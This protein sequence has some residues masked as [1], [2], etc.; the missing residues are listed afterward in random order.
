MRGSFS[1]AEFSGARTV[2]FFDESSSRWEADSMSRTNL[3]GVS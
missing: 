2:V 3:E 1:M